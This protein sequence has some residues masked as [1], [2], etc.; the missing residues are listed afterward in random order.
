MLGTPGD[1]PSKPAYDNIP[2]DILRF[3]VR[4]IHDLRKAG[5]RDIVI[6]P[7]F[8]FGKTVRQNFTLLTRLGVFRFLE[9]P[10]MIGISRKSMIWRTLEISPE[11]ALNGTTA[12]HMVALQQGVHI[13]RVHDVRPAMETIRLFREL[14]S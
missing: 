3:L 12:L 7:G 8:G 9:V 14:A 4:R 11:E 13:L 5:I 6:D 2:G 10:L 1:M